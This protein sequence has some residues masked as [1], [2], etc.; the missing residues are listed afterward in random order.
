MVLCMEKI[1]LLAPTKRKQ[2][3]LHTLL[4]RGLFGVLLSTL[5]FGASVALANDKD[6]L[7]TRYSVMSMK[8]AGSLLVDA[9]NI[10]G[11]LVV[12]GARGHI[13]VSRDNGKS[14]KQAKVP[15]QNLITAVY[16]ASSDLG[17][18]VGHEAV[19]L[20]TKDGGDSWDF[21]YGAPFLPAGYDDYADDSADD[22]ADLEAGASD[23][24]LYA[25]DRT[26]SPLLDVWFKNEKEGFAVGAYGYFLH[27]SDAGKTWEDWSK[28]LGNIDDWHLNA[29]SSL[30]GN[31]VYVAGEKGVLFRSANGGDSWD[32]L[33]SP[34]DGSF[35]GMVV[36]PGLNEMIMFGLQ[37]HI[38]RTS[39]RGENWRE[40]ETEN[41]NG[42]MAGT[43]Y[44]DRGVIL[45]GNGGVMMFSKDDGNSFAKQVTDDRNS[46]AGIVKTDKNKL[47]LVG[48]NGVKLATPSKS[49]VGMD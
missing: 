22:G 7:E 43:L 9:V 34:Y 10:N 5:S 15:T 35:F 32:V 18:A 4:L 13:L 48:Q 16:F 25:I 30:D 1:T 26:G 46:I 49:L 14:W 31:L 33:T 41:Q 37:G 19:I 42:L 11:K 2:A 38:F 39:D 44:G 29:I 24:N 17:W 45:V 6:K 3:T 23:E 20:Q 8:A 28:R 21:Q 12:V 47:V 27:T 36:G 40:I